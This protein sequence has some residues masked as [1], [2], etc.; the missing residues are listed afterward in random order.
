MIVGFTGTRKGTTAK[1]AVA[2]SDW[3]RR[4]AASITDAHHGCCVGADEDFGGAVVAGALSVSVIAHPSNIAAMTSRA[5]LA[6]ADFVRDAL[7]PLDRNRD[8]VDA[9]DVLLACP[10][11]MA[12][13]QRSGTWATVRYARRLKKRIVI[14]WPDGT[15]TQENEQ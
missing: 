12:E 15:T 2:L 1:Q 13:E 3:I 4:Y 7:P 5:A 14:F 8:I 6:A 9:S 11:G 10:Q